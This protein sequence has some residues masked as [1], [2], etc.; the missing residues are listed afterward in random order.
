METRSY[1]GAEDSNFRPYSITTLILFYI[2][3]FFGWLFRK[4]A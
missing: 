3:K 4:R 2:G 1:L